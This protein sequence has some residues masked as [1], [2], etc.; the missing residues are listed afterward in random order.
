MG[1]QGPREA[2]ISWLGDQGGRVDIEGRDSF[3]S[4]VGGVWSF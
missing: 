3:I 4:W 2:C 1:V